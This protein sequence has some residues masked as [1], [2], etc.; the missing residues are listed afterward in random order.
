MVDWTGNVEETLVSHW[1]ASDG[2]KV[3]GFDGNANEALVRC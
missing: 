3:C 2:R 1:T